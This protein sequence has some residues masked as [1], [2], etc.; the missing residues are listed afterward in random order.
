MIIVAML[1]MMIMTINKMEIRADGAMTE[2]WNA[3]QA[4]Y[5]NMNSAAHSIATNNNVIVQLTV[6]LHEKLLY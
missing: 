4:D 3:S 5:T 1:V 6:V 2:N